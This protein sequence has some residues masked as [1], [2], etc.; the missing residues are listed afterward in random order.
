[1]SRWQ[2]PI[3]WQWAKT[4]EISSI[5]GGG[6]PST[7]NQ[8]NFIDKGVPWITPADLSGYQDEY[9]SRGKRDLSEKGYRDSGAQLMPKDTVLFTS[10]APIGYCV[11]AAN[12]ISTNQGFKSFVLKGGINPKYVRHYLLSSK[13]YA[14]SL[15]SG[16]TFKELSGNR[17]ARLEIPVPPLNEQKRIVARI[18]ELQARSRRAREALDTVPD[19]LDQ[20]RQSILAAA[21]RGDLTKVWRKKQTD[22]EPAKELLKRIRAERRKRWEAAE[23]EKLKAKGLT[24]EKLKEAYVNRRKKYKEPFSVAADALPKLPHGWCWSS[25]DTVAFVTKLAGF[26]YT[27]YVKYDAAGDMAVIKAENAGKYGFKRTAFS[28]IQSTTINHL[29]E[30]INANVPLKARL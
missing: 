29:R 19:L 6:T 23:L 22:I 3:G 15:A 2:I 9:I 26:E 28:R 11:L 27:K 18:E 20:L 30:Y 14:E 16:S 8:S 17:I 21:F 4:I 10:R 13:Q 24:D 5:V 7:K 12:E 25:I 1:M